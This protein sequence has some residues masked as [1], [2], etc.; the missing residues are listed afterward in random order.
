MVSFLPEDGNES[1][2]SETLFKIRIATMDNV[3]KIELCTCIIP[4]KLSKMYYLYKYGTICDSS[5]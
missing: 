2:V 5:M 4:G 3:H 1:Q